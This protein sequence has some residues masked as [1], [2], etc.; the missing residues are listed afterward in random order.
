MN[1]IE[2]AL[3]KLL[4]VSTGCQGSSAVDLTQFEW[5]QLY[6]EAFEH[7]IQSII[8]TE[9][10]KYG[11]S[12]SPELFTRWKNETIMQV[13]RYNGY[14]SVVGDLL[15]A[16]EKND[17]PVI[18]LKGLH[19]KYLYKDPEMRTMGDIDL[20]TTQSSL[21]QA[22]DVIQSFGYINVKE[23]DPKHYVFIHK[24]FIPIELHFSL[25]TEAK[26]RIAVNFN[27]EIWESAYCFERDG[28]KFLVPS[29]VNQLIYCCIHMTNHLGKGGFGLRQLSDFNLLARSCG[30]SIDW[31]HLMKKANLYGI[32]KFVEVMLV[33]CHELFALDV[34][35]TLISQYVTQKEYVD[36][37]INMILDAG[38]FGGKDE[39]VSTNRIIASYMS[40]ASNSYASRLSYIFPS[41][42][43]LSTS[44][45]YVQK[46]GLLVPVAWVHRIINNL[47]RKDIS[48]SEK[49]PDAKAV[50]EY[51]KL[52][53][54][55]DIKR[56]IS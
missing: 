4:S 52:F 11:S 28:M 32:G 51:V 26:R 53:R 42:E 39:K 31:D 33:I 29:D 3:V 23:G 24:N 45:P 6:K 19:Y 54:W 15:N 17:I 18:V 36:N 5:N 20:L 12:I 38:A 49:I 55:L 35:E 21:K 40:E 43:K 8:Y 48:L 2:K 44:Y 30:K 14:L 16:F 22:S 25:F 37:T 9:A 50:D 7:Q 41:R 10:S 27:K 1:E 13:L 47:L 34:P 56:N 46:S